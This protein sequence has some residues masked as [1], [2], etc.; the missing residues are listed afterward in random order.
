MWLWVTLWLKLLR[1]RLIVARGF[2]L[3][4][5]IV[6]LLLLLGRLMERLWALLREWRHV[7][8]LPHLLMGWRGS[9]RVEEE[10]SVRRR[11]AERWVPRR[12]FHVDGLTRSP[13]L[14]LAPLVLLHA[15]HP[16][17]GPEFSLLIAVVVPAVV[18]LLRLCLCLA[19]L[20]SISHHA[21][22]GTCAARDHHMVARR[23]GRSLLVVVYAIVHSHLEI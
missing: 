7:W 15:C 3:L 13:L 12:R 6:G 19:P 22:I 1:V 9:A 2:G 10:R 4:E 8:E 20:L 16:Q 23:C 14:L 11:R 18:H 21:R 5:R 17:G